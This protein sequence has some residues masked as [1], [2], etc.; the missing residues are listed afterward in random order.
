MLYRNVFLTF[1]FIQA[2]YKSCG[3]VDIPTKGLLS[4]HEFLNVRFGKRFQVFLWFYMDHHIFIGA[5][6][7]VLYHF[8]HV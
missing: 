5:I 7:Y 6:I 8:N 2:K 3:I 1:A 4:G